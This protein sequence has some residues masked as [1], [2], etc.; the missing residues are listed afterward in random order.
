MKMR[1]SESIAAAWRRWKWS[2][3]T[4]GEREINRIFAELSSQDQAALKR[5]WA[6][7]HDRAKEFLRRSQEEHI[8]RQNGLL[9]ERIAQEPEARRKQQ[10]WE[11]NFALLA[12]VEKTLEAPEIDEQRIAWLWESIQKITSTTGF[13]GFQDLRAEAWIAAAN[14]HGRQGNKADELSCLEYA[15]EL[16]PKAPVKRRVKALRSAG[17]I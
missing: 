7:E 4:E 1:I 8:A 14:L 12:E 17:G 13:E 10:D 9:Y 15:L 6:K 3:L 2:R 16:N 11:N 5:E